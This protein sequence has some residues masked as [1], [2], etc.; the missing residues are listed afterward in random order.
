MI[1]GILGFKDLYVEQIQV[2]QGTQGSV[3]EVWNSDDRV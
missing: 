2:R 3:S 1:Y